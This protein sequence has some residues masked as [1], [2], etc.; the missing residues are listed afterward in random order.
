MQQPNGTSVEYHCPYNHLLTYSMQHSP[1]SEANRSSASQEIP[2]ILRNPKIHYR[3]Y[4]CPPPI[5]ILSQIN[6]V[7]VL[8]SHF[9]K[10]NFNIILT[11]KHGP[12]KWL[13]SLR[14]PHQNPVHTSLLPA[15]CNM[16]H[17]SHSS[18]IGHPND[19]SRAVEVS[20]INV[21]DQDV[22]FTWTA[23]PQRDVLFLG[24]RNEVSQCMWHSSMRLYTCHVS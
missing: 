1:S 15:T 14:F 23:H 21:S 4:K 18:R 2:R 7:H 3:I 16:S 9:L 11:P 13:L 20:Q 22:P 17:P 6:P 12:Y 5:H 8:T 19:I 24:A 10:I